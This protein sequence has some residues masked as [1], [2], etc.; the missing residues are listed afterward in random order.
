VPLLS[1]HNWPLSNQQL[2]VQAPGLC[3]TALHLHGR[4]CALACRCLLRPAVRDRGRRLGIG[5]G[6]GTASLALQIL[7]RRVLLL[8]IPLPLA[9]QRTARRVVAC[10]TGA[11]VLLSP[12]VCDPAIHVQPPL[13]A[14]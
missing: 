9:R 3:A 12:Y 10:V 5:L 1:P 6:L 7:L 14:L 13:K 2:L 8:R 11:E 4:L